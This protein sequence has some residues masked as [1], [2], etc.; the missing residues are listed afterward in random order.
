MEHKQM[1]EDFLRK[2]LDRLRERQAELMRQFTR[3]DERAAARKAQIR[4]QYI[5]NGGKAE[6]FECDWPK[7][8][9]QI[10]AKGETE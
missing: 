8:L 6:D 4:E 2:D 7:L 1:A 3:A 5:A 10:V 9:I